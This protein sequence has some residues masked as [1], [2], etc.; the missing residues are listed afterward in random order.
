MNA[1]VVPSSAAPAIVSI[2]KKSGL[3][4]FF[5]A[6][7]L[8]RII[9][10][11][12]A[13]NDLWDLRQ[14]VSVVRTS[15]AFPGSDLSDILGNSAGSVEPGHGI[16]ADDKPQG[17]PHFIEW[18]TPAPVAIRSFRLFAAGDGPIYNNEREFTRFVLKAKSSLLSDFDVVLYDATFPHPFGHDDVENREL[19]AANISPVFTSEFRAEF[20]QFDGQRGYDGP[21]VI[22]LDGFATALDCVPKPPGLLGWWPGD[23]S[24]R[25]AISGS[26]AEILGTMTYGTGEVGQAFVFDSNHGHVRIPASPSTTVKTGSGLT[27]EAWINP[28]ELQEQHPIVEWNSGA[29]YG[30]HFYLSVIPPHG[31]GP[32]SL[33]ANLVDEAG[34]DHV[35]SSLGGV[36]KTGVFQ[37]AAVTY[38]KLTGRAAL[39]LNGA[40]LRELNLG[41]FEPQTSYDLLLGY[42]PA[43]FDGSP[44]VF[45]GALDEPSL[46]SRALSQ[47][48]ILSIFNAGAA[49]KC[50][51]QLPEPPTGLLASWS[52]DE[53]SGSIA[54]DALGKMDGTLSAGASFVAG[55]VK[56]NAL[57]LV[58]ESNGFVNFGD[59]LGLTHSDFSLV[60]WMKMN[61]G[62]RSENSLLLAKHEAGYDNGYF[63]NVNR[64]GIRGQEDKVMFYPGPGLDGPLSTSLVND[65]AWHQVVLTH[66]RG[67]NDQL[68][69][70]GRLAESTLPSQAVASSPAPLLL[71]GASFDG[72]PTGLFTGLIDEV[73]V[74]NRALTPD[75]VERLYRNPAP[76]VTRPAWVSTLSGLGLPGGQDGPS[77]AATFNAPNGGA[78]FQNQSVL[79]ADTQNHRIRQV[80][81]STGDSSTLAGTGA[82]GY[83]DGPAQS[84]LFSSPLGAIAGV[85]GD[86]FVADSGNNRIRRIAVSS[87][88]L[89]STV[90]GSGLR[91]YVDGP[92][93]SAQFDGPNDLA[94]DS[95]GNL[96]V[97]EFNNH[98]I[99]K[100]T[101]G[102]QVSTFAGD[103]KPGFSDG[104]G[105]AASFNQPSGLAFDHQGNLFV[106]EWGSHRIRR[107]TPAGTV[108]TFAGSVFRGLV[109]AQGV[110]AR[111][112]QPDGIVVDAFDVLYVTEQG[113]HTIR[114]VTPVGDVTTIAG[115]GSA[116][117]SDGLGIV[118]RFAAPG[119]IGIDAAGTLYVADTVN[120][121]IRKIEFLSPP[122]VSVTPSQRT[123]LAGQTVQFDAL[124]TPGSPGPIR[125]EWLLNGRE[126]PGATAAAFTI[127][128][129]LPENSGTYAV[130]VTTPAGVADSAA[131]VLAVVNPI[132]FDRQ[133]PGYYSSGVRVRVTLESRASQVSGPAYVYAVM[134]TPPAG[135]TV[136]SI[137]DGGAFDRANGAIKFGPFF[138]LSHRALSY[139]LVPPAGDTGTK[140]FSG[141]TSADGFDVPIGG[142]ASILPAPLH[143]ADLSPADNRITVNELTV[144]AS[145]WKRGD[146]WSVH[147][148]PIPLDYVTR[149][150]FLWKN[151]ETY[152]LDPN[153]PAPVWWNPAPGPRAL[154]PSA[155]ATN[156]AGATWLVPSAYVPGESFQVRVRIAPPSGVS[157]YALEA[158]V[159]ETLLVNEVNEGGTFDAVRHVVRWGLFFDSTQR[160]LS[161]S[162]KSFGSLLAAVI[163]TGRLSFDGSDEAISGVATIPPS[164]R[165]AFLQRS[166]E[167]RFGLALGQADGKLYLIESSPDLRNWAPLVTLMNASGILQFDDP[168]ASR[169]AQRFYRVRSTVMVDGPGQV[170]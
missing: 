71:G 12:Q 55:G 147:P 136:A 104:I 144:Y 161:F 53:A 33:F 119:G 10:A 139:E 95:A 159:P 59:V 15:G 18:R 41:L 114:R 88:S 19:L 20:Y 1:P 34:I 48:E 125:Y 25:D 109:D 17:Y 50:Q 102:G 44:F 91:G 27:L 3:M 2:L 98:T 24:A 21:R 4:A 157:V 105:T 115:T 67:A 77:G 9:Q 68:Y 61:P 123:V 22:E 75:A 16:F 80:N 39:Y 57:R 170:P 72:N 128:R 83:Q 145:A 96:Y 153:L 164:V 127:P 52:F 37:H 122:Q 113:N 90:A 43:G 163:L 51:E 45:A 166:A 86:V 158:Q 116:G 49:G 132:Q 165:L 74:Y 134:E 133:L 142:A 36:V 103:G 5:L 69:V 14:G 110:R 169:S 62:D 82:A 76:T 66:E 149:A 99:R 92:A 89:V 65:G 108:T 138:D 118:A 129:A 23:E 107:I 137:G 31:G 8:S 152:R 101:A 28:S 26:S 11:A 84:A 78:V 106:T 160:E 40:L 121:R 141:I 130:R 155:T 32:G 162:A 151:G 124:V 42:R 112:D 140:T 70:D 35:I 81:V 30:A 63:L 117:Y 13:T 111:F 100:I 7:S 87:A 135:W 79:V 148:S 94:I 56:G 146:P 85:G 47:G 64:S 54:H 154:S 60:L 143:P 131:S 97:S 126:I 120:N 168:E 167:G 38:E 93:A 156:R 73:Q 150:G 29:A 6:I 46:Y 58:R